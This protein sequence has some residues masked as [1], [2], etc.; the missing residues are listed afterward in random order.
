MLRN[1]FWK[2]SLSYLLAETGDRLAA[3]ELQEVSEDIL[4]CVIFRTSIEIHCNLWNF[5]LKP[6]KLGKKKKKA[7]AFLNQNNFIGVTHN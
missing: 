3:G 5:R 6:S 4:M 7:S 1:L 2:L